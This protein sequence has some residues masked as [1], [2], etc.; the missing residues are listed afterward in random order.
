MSALVDREEATALAYDFVEEAQDHHKLVEHDDGVVHSEFLVRDDDRLHQPHE[1]WAWWDISGDG[2]P[3]TDYNDGQ[4]PDDL[5]VDEAHS[6]R[7]Q[8]APMTTYHGW[9]RGAG[10]WVLLATDGASWTP[11]AFVPDDGGD[12]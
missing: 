5:R 1:P 4:A 3:H 7:H 8:D 6:V 2:C 12:Q 10:G 11:V 9:V